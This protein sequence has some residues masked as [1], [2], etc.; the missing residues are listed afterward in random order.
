MIWQDVHTLYNAV[1]L[2]ITCGGKQVLVIIVDT[3]SYHM[4]D[5]YGLANA[6]QIFHH[7]VGV[8]AMMRRKAVVQIVVHGLNVEKDEI[9]DLQKTA[10]GIV[11]DN[12][13]GVQGRMYAL[14]TTE[15]EVCLYERS[16]DERFTTGTGYASCL[17]KV[18]IAQGFFQQ[19][20]RCPFVLDWGLEVPRVWVVAEEATHGAALHEG[21]ETYA[22]PVYRA[23]GFQGVDTTYEGGWS[24]CHSWGKGILGT[25]RT[26]GS[27]RSLETL[28]FRG[29]R[30]CPSPYLYI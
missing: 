3:G 8:R 22:R 24:I 26:L 14:F 1:L 9:R 30:T 16:L 20:L 29:E 12:T 4:A 23:E 7:L 27:L 13:A 15:T 18:A 2:Y 19:L 5:P 28:G 10:H 21:E 11:K 6:L 17:D 25:L